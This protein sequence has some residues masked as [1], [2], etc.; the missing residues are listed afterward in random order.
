MHFQSVRESISI[1]RRSVRE[2]EPVR[3]R[4]NERVK[5]SESR[6]QDKSSKMIPI[7]LANTLV[8]ICSLALIGLRKCVKS[9]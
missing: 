1:G 6:E 2:R 9:N 3:E 7:I 4:M 5:E 8:M